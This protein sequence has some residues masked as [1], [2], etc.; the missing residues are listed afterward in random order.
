MAISFKLK[1]SGKLSGTAK[2]VADTLVKEA[3][4]D[5]APQVAQLIEQTVRDVEESKVKANREAWA[6]RLGCAVE[7]HKTI[8]DSAKALAKA[9]VKAKAVRLAM[10]A[11]LTG[12][13]PVEQARKGFGYN[14]A[15][16]L[17]EL[18]RCIAR[19]G[20]SVDNHVCED[21]AKARS[22]FAPH[23]SAPGYILAYWDLATALTLAN[24]LRK[25]RAQDQQLAKAV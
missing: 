2:L 23:K 18:G 22:G 1:A 15:E 17:E 5:S 16:V 24:E 10:A 9:V 14:A 20:D 7:D 11:K 6:A 21:K 12:A 4:Q 3:D 8:D 25:R 19:I 13:Q